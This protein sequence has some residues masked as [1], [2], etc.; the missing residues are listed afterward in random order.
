MQGRNIDDT[1]QLT[2]A[3]PLVTAIQNDRERYN[4]IEALARMWLAADRPAAEAWVEQ[5]DLPDA[6]KQDLLH[7]ETA[8]N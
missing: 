2:Q 8:K 7:P 1:Q 5:T 4:A 3:A 6:D